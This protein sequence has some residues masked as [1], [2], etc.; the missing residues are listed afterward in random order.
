VIESRTLK[1]GDQ[2]MVRLPE[3]LGIAAD[4]DVTIRYD[5]TTLAIKHALDPIEEKC[6]LTEMLRE[7]NAIWANAPRPRSDYTEERIEFPD[8]PGL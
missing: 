1:S 2:V 5:G 7:I 4:V 6:K 3:E 8:R